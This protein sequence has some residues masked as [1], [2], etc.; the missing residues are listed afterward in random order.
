MPNSNLILFETHRASLGRFLV[1]NLQLNVRVLPIPFEELNGIACII[2]WPEQLC[3][4]VLD[5]LKIVWAIKCHL[6]A[7][8]LPISKE[9][10]LLRNQHT[11]YGLKRFV[12]A[13]P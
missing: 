5:L 3:D 7:V 9:V 10:P 13:S 1:G 4:T 8:K 11:K 12:C 6:T 2:R